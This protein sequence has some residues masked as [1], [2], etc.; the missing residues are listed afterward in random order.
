ME[1]LKKHEDE[2]QFFRRELR[3]RRGLVTTL[4][5]GWL[6]NLLYEAFSDYGQSAGRPLRPPTPA[7]RSMPGA[8]GASG[9]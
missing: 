3:A 5:G 8:A 9:R 2:E 4:S 6:L 1:R 7:G